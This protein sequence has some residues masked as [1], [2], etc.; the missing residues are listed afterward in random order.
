MPQVGQ[1][2]ESAVLLEWVVQC[3]D[4]VKATDVVADMMTLALA[5]DHRVVDGSYAADFLKDLKQRLE[6]FEERVL[7][8]KP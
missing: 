3:G 4:R 2:I 8:S 7:C 5:C 6:Q 1:D